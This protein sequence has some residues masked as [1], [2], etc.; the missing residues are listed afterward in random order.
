VQNTADMECVNLPLKA[1]PFRFCFSQR[2]IFDRISFW[3]LNQGKFK[4][5]VN[6]CDWIKIDGRLWNKIRFHEKYF[7]SSFIGKIQIDKCSLEKWFK[8]KRIWF[9]I[10]F[11][12]LY[13]YLLWFTT[14]LNRL[15][16]SKNLLP[17]ILQTFTCK[18]L[19][20]K[21]LETEIIWMAC[22]KGFTT[23]YSHHTIFRTSILLSQNHWPLQ[24]LD[25]P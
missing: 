3:K 23:P 24:E 19:R 13:I 18:Y 16:Y 5:K 8:L 4:L 6:I 15:T 14:S 20:Q 21:V 25:D 10:R 22:P 11:E 2:K 9:I 1:K 7:Q 12:S 17:G